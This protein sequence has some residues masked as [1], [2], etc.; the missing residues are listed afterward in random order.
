VTG[1]RGGGLSARPAAVATYLAIEAPRD[2]RPS[3]LSRRVAAIRHMHIEAGHEMLTAHRHVRDVVA[4]IR[5]AKGTVPTVR[6]RP[7]LTGSLPC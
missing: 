6:P 2:I 5:N 1:A 7:R 4:G 3:T